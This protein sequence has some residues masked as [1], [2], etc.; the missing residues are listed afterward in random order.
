ME[1]F[2]NLGGINSCSELFKAEITFGDGT[3][4]TLGKEI[5]DAPESESVPNVS[6]SGEWNSATNKMIKL[7][8]DANNKKINLDLSAMTG[9]KEIASDYYTSNFNVA[10]LVLPSCAE[11]ICDGAFRDQFYIESIVIPEGVKTIGKEAFYG[12]N[13]LKNVT[14]S[15]S[16]TSIGDKAFQLCD[17]YSIFV[18]SEVIGEKVFCSNLNLTEITIGQKV[19]KICDWA[20]S[21]TPIKSI[22]VPDNV[23][24]LGAGIF[25]WC[26]QLETADIKFADDSEDSGTSMFESCL[27]LKNVTI[28]DGSVKIPAYAFKCCESLETIDIPASVKTIEQGAFLKCTS[29]KEANYA[30]KEGD[31]TIDDTY[32]YNDIIKNVIKYNGE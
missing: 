14:I 3:N 16:V 19:T 21:S 1:E 17:I 11:K 26:D 6:F 10:E 29:L 30:G 31:L 8:I 13:Y 28:R 9:L 32:N 4:W 18:D 5:R 7:S 23:K 20:F 27:K 24:N 12:C 2:A 22:T 25:Q 15:S